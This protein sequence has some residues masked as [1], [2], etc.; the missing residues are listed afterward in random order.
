MI[1]Y[2]DLMNYSN[3]LRFCTSVNNLTFS[4]AVIINIHRSIDVHFIYHVL[5]ILMVVNI[6]AIV[7]K[8][9]EFIWKITAK[10]PFLDLC[11]LHC[12]P[13]VYIGIWFGTAATQK[14]WFFYFKLYACL[15]R[16]ADQKQIIL[17]LALSTSWSISHKWW[18]KGILLTF[19]IFI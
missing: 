9:S 19:D 18:C 3:L 6:F 14:N 7:L 12:R 10:Y 11:S 15:G 1:L 8:N 17:L 5:F 13:L 16:E 2:F 4:R